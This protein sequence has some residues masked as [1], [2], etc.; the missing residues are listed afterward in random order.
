MDLDS[1]AKHALNIMLEG[2]AVLL[3]TIQE[4]NGVM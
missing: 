1:E 3:L 2:I 4:L